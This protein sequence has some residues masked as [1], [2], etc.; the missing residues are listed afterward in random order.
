M[1]DDGYD[2]YLWQ[3]RM[4]I[5]IEILQ[6]SIDRA[7]E[8]TEEI[9]RRRGEHSKMELTWEVTVKVPGRA[10]RGKKFTDVVEM[11]EYIK[12]QRESLD[13]TENTYTITQRIVLTPVE[14]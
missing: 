6:M 8:R 4:E 13:A 3:A 2:S 5:A 10:G 12:K 11:N 9:I 7:N 14:A 1:I